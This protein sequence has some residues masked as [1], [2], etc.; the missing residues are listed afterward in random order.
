MGFHDWRRLRSSGKELDDLQEPWKS[1]VAGR[2][3]IPIITKIWIVSFRFQERTVVKTKREKWLASKLTLT[4]YPRAEVSDGP[5][6]F[7][8]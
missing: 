4:L 3:G 5:Q 8:E 1:I 7:N 2:A 6:F